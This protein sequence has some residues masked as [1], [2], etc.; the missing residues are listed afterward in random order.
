MFVPIGKANR[1]FVAI[2]SVLDINIR[3]IV[4]IAGTIFFL[5][6][7]LK[8]ECVVWF[9][10]FNYFFAFLSFIKNILLRHCCTGSH[11]H[12]FPTVCVLKHAHDI[13]SRS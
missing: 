4:N 9:V 6:K 8:F 7:E 3:S 1:S 2:K 10:F 5:F 12:L 13:L 11:M